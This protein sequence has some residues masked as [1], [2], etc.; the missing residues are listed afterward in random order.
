LRFYAKKTKYKIQSNNNSQKT[1]NKQITMTKIQNV[2][3][4]AFDLIGDLDIVIC[5]LFVIWCLQF[6]I[7][8]LFGLGF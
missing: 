6:V 8:G 3:Q 4:L 5:Y 2:K 1:N 7:S